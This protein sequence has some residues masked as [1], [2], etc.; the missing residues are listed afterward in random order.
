MA[1]K[2]KP[3]HPKP[4]EPIVKPLDGENPPVTPIPPKPK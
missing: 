2:P 4:D 1:K 3:E